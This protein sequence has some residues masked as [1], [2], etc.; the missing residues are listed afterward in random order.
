MAKRKLLKFGR[1]FCAESMPVIQNLIIIFSLFYAQSPLFNSE[2]GK[3]RPILEQKGLITS[4]L[5]R[6]L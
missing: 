2:P 6:A 4:S 3:T 5:F 1:V